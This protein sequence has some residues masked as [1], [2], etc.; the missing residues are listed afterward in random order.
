MSLPSVNL[1]K[2]FLSGG[3]WAFSGKMLTSLSA[4]AVSALLARLLTPEEMGTYFLI[5]SL[6][7]VATVIAQLGFTQT[8]VRLVAE[9]MGAGKPERARQSVFLVL[10]A[11][12]V[13]AIIVAA[14]IALGIGEWIST[15]ILHSNIMV[16]VMGLVAVWVV[17]TIFQQLIAEIFRGFHDIRFATIFGGLITSLLSAALFLALWFFQRSGN[18]EQIIILALLA[19][20]SSVVVSI[21]ILRRRVLELPKSSNVIDIK[22]ILIISWPLWIT[23]LTLIILT[24]VDIW[25]LGMF[26]TQE[27]VAIYGATVKFMGLVVM[28]LVIV[29]LVVPPVIAELYSQGKIEKLERALRTTATIAAIPS[30]VVLGI[31]VIF[32]GPILGLIYGSFYSEG[33]YILIILSVGQLVNVWAGSCGLA[34]MLTG[35]QLTMMSITIFCGM[36]V[37][38]G[39]WWLVPSY[40]GEGVAAAAATGMFL[41]NLLMLF[42]AK[43][44]I[45]V[46]THVR[47]SSV[48]ELRGFF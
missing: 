16:K 48:K 6:V 45:G 43:K 33:S 5:F 24:Q 42:F 17:V 19:S 26:R 3:V 47:F 4:L 36:W 18:L 39:A 20:A 27:E 1:K 15:Y 28:P 13:S 23:S 22:D 32:G 35:H 44:K 11:T 34:L 7:S 41:Q 9:S 31:L 21:I 40:G 38:L 37:V 29:N 14:F 12:G 46:W 10:R 25:V 2:R 30:F 8:I